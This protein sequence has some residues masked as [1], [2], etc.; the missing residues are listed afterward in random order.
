VLSARQLH[1]VALAP[2]LEARPRFVILDEPISARDLSVQTTVLNV[3]F[4]LSRRFGLTYLFVS[5]QLS[6]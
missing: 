5:H 6:V 2:I 4:E 1:R 3:L